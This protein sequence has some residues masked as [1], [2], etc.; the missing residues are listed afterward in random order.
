MLSVCMRANRSFRTLELQWYVPS[1]DFLI[2]LRVLRRGTFSSPPPNDA[3]MGLFYCLQVQCK[4]QSAWVKSPPFCNQNH[5]K[6]PCASVSH[7]AC[8][9]VVSRSTAAELSPKCTA[10]APITRSFFHSKSALVLAFTDVILSE[11]RAAMYLR[12][13]FC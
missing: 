13:S 8:C 9:A 3:R 11:Q 5:T 4:R 1:V 7:L 6:H 2:P 12:C 10:L